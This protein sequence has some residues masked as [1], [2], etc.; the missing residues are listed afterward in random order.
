VG[1]GAFAQR[2]KE[3]IN[4]LAEFEWN[5]VGDYTYQYIRQENGKILK[6]GP[7]SMVATINDKGLPYK[8]RYTAN[9]IGK[10]NLTGNHSNGNLHG[11]LSLDANLSLNATNGDK[12]NLTYTFRGNFKNGIPDGNFKV[13]Y[14][15][16]NIKVNVNYR[17]SI[18]VGGYYV[19]GIGDDSLPFT[20]SG[21]LTSSGKLTGTWKF[22]SVYGTTEITYSNGVVLNRK[23]Y[24]ADLRA[25]AQLYASGA[26]SIE[27]LMKENICVK[28]DYILLGSTAW[29]QI[30][31][32]G[33]AFDKMGGY[34]FSRSK[35]VE[36]E[37]LDRLP[38]LSSDGFMKFKEGIVEY[39]K[40]GGTLDDLGTWDNL[41]DERKVV[42]ESYRKSQKLSLDKT[43]GLYFMNVHHRDQL[44][45]YCIGYPD[46]S[47]Y[48]EDIYLSEDQ[49][50][51]IRQLMHEARMD[52][53]DKTS[54]AD[55]GFSVSRG[56]ENRISEYF[57][58]SECDQD[59]LTYVLYNNYRSD[60]ILYFSRDAFENYFINLGYGEEILKLSPE[61]RR[62][63]VQTKIEQKLEE[64][65]LKLEEEKR[66]AAELEEARK[67]AF[68]N[69]CLT[70]A[71]NWFNTKIKG[72]PKVV[73][74]ET[75]NMPDSLYPIVSYEPKEAILLDESENEGVICK[76]ISL[77]NVEYRDNYSMTKYKTYEMSVFFSDDKSVDMRLTFAPSNFKR[78]S[79]DYDVIQGLDNKIDSNNKKF[80]ELS[81]AEF[82]D[83]Y[84]AYNT[85]LKEEY[86][87]TINHSDL[88]SSINER[89]KIL[90]LQDT[91]LLFIDKLV[92]INKGDNE[93]KLKCGD[94]ND[95]LKAYSAYAKT[96][97]LT[98]S[99]NLNL[100]KIEGYIVVQEGVVKFID[101]LDQIQKGD[102]DITSMCGDNKDVIK[103][104]SAYARTRDLAWSPDWSLEKLDEYV[105]VQIRVSEFLD[106]LAEIEEVDA[107]ITSKCDDKKDVLKAYSTYAETRDLSWSPGWSLEKLEG[108]VAVQKKCLEFI[109]LRAIVMSNETK[110]DGLK[111]SAPTMNKAYSAFAS[112]CDI[113]WTPEVDFVSINSLIDIQNKYLS[114][115]NKDGVKEIDKMIKKHKM[116]DIIKILEM[117]ELK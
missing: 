14:P 107:E 87:L 89:N 28:S 34:S 45:E 2:Q 54:I 102:A 75:R 21:T 49:Y 77:V 56:Y 82:K 4:F 25:K 93:V 50:N 64:E 63:I 99:P 66:K 117:E 100:E 116:T 9:L 26:I 32:N 35:S 48:S 7:F 94:H 33:I 12:E 44:S 39:I 85:Y 46:W 84:K 55:I 60:N 86:K 18:L 112:S 114:A 73:Y 27:E 57:K 90:A 113:A 20:T 23:D 22:Q 92:A 59:V 31:S 15:S 103:A 79:N 29:N 5:F 30:L 74:T 91:T 19:K 83:G 58:P 61:N 78:I 88:K 47:D 51:E 111:S 80:K 76:V 97:D 96:R 65:R 16:Y 106:K 109:D 3:T 72:Q 98:W 69:A 42:L 13:D 41:T 53:I 43:C 24:D 95:I 17:D 6:D 81:S 38:M 40:N 36:Y 71:I 67:R 37:Y 101:I 110:I 70:K 62:E 10:Y 11:A 52:N 104:Y 1:I 68:K 8:Y 108:Y 105:A 115:V